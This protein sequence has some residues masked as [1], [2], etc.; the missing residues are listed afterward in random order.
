MEDDQES[1][2]VCQRLRCWQASSG[3]S[4]TQ[5]RC[6][7]EGGALQPCASHEPSAWFVPAL[8]LALQAAGSR[9]LLAGPVAQVGT[10][11]LPDHVK[12]T[13][14]VSDFQS[15]DCDLKSTC[16][17]PLWRP[18]KLGLIPYA[19]RRAVVFRTAEEPSLVHFDRFRSGDFVE[20]GRFRANQIEPER[21]WSQGSLGKCQNLSRKRNVS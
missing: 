6:C 18:V 2:I 16:D 13:C 7:S 9:C 1:R 10:C 21:N 17:S 4:C 8:R 3:L 12:R 5:H 20:F 15:P 14:C 11:C 19:C